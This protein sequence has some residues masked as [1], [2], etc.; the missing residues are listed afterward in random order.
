[1]NDLWKQAVLN[2]SRSTH[3][4]FKGGILQNALAQNLKRIGFM[5]QPVSDFIAIILWNKTR[6]WEWMVSW[7]GLFQMT[8]DL[9][10]LI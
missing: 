9:Y 2:G 4:D 10:T 3:S 6:K 7:N 5:K 8:T 1:M